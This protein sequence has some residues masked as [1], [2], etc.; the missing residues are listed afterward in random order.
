MKK[1]ILFFAAVLVGLCSFSQNFQPATLVTSDGK[2]LEG[3]INYKNWKKNP[4]KIQFR[5]HAASSSATQE[6]YT[7]KDLKSFT[8]SG[9]YYAAA[10]VEVDYRSDNPGSL[11]SESNIIVR[12]DTVFLRA[13]VRGTKSLYHFYDIA[14]HFYILKDE[15][16]ELLRY[17]KYISASDGQGRVYR[18]N[19]TFAMQLLRYFEGCESLSP[20]LEK[21]KYSA[22]HLTAAFNNY[23]KCTSQTPDFMQVRESE[24]LEF[25]V[26]AGVSNTTFKVHNSSPSNVMSVMSKTK[27]STSMNFAGGIFMDIVFP[28]QRGRLSLNN[29][30][31]YSSYETSGTYRLTQSPTR[32]EEHSFEFAY[33]Y[34]KLNN[35][36]RY[37]FLL[38]KSAIFINGG[39]STGFLLTNHSK[40][41][42]FRKFDATENRAV[43]NAFNLNE[44]KY[45]LGYLAG[46]GFRKSRASLELRAERGSGPIREMQTAARVYRYYA[47][48]GYRIK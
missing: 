44:G 33:S 28:R 16:F 1:L 35:M 17:K 39:V 21:V 23:Y 22:D 27:F 31:T 14:D 8:V 34:V 19:R 3:E 7:A 40:L 4:A 20:A 11:T 25:G 38:D 45:E 10:I 30:L 36:L 9:D 37:K 6:T 13:L 48:L 42:K 29:E 12:R 5:R 32:F 26:L 43:D 46:V 18:Y 24:K 47:L 41:T 2:S 15:T